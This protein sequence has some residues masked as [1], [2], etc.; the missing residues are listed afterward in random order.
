M[1]RDHGMCCFTYLKLNRKYMTHMHM[2]K[3]GMILHV[4]WKNTKRYYTQSTHYCVHKD[5]M[6]TVNGGESF[7]FILF[8]LRWNQ[9]V[10]RFFLSYNDTDICGQHTV[11]MLLWVWEQKGI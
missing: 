9:L 6:T 10:E 7:I 3:N 1:N 4:M 5:Y 8:I 11:A 2:E